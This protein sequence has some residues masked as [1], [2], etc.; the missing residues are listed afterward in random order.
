MARKGARLTSAESVPLGDGVTHEDRGRRAELWAAMTDERERL[1][2][3]RERVADERQRLADQRETLADRHDR[4]LDQ[5]AEHQ[6]AAADSLAGE[7][8]ETAERAEVEAALR[9]AREAVQRAQAQLLRAEQAAARVNARAGRRVAARERVEASAVAA[10]VTD[11]EEG[12]WLADRRD[13]VAAERDVQGE[14]RGQQADRRDEEADQRERRADAREQDAL[15]RERRDQRAWPGGGTAPGSPR[16]GQEISL[17]DSRRA[18]G[19]QREAATAARRQEA[20]SRARAA[21]QWRPQAYG[22]TLMA[23]FADLTRHL[24]TSDD[25]DAVLPRVLTFAVDAIPG[26]DWAGVTLWHDGRPV[27]TVG[28]DPVA[29]ELEAV[30]A[31]AAAGPALDA[32]REEHLIV[33]SR[34]GDPA[35]WPLF[36]AAAARLGVGSALCHGLFLRGAQGWSPVGVLSLYG[37]AADAFGE[38]DQEF[39][40]IMAAYLSVAVAMARRRDE[41]ERREA[42]LHRGLS[43][44]DVIGQAKGILMER[45]RL[46]AGEAFDLLRRVSQRLNRRLA[47][48]AEHLARTGELPR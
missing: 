19:R 21:A 4:V 1:A 22:P 2:D 3:E 26:C 48:V 6:R 29:S 33:R 35:R 13:F 24:F 42:A 34:V 41:V 7:A 40:A 8:D 12:A 39:S 23:S 43:S 31:A 10:K 38:D 18:A 36:E 20:V 9:R 37:A 11:G 5:R 30:Q 15:S 28:S 14:R 45:Q 32:M 16:S 44:R 47:E 27:D 17:A 46:S 25:L